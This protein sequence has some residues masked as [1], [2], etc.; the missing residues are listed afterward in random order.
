MAVLQVLNRL[1]ALY[2][3]WYDSYASGGNASRLI[4]I[5]FSRY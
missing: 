1:N 5:F 3:N 2:E 4:L